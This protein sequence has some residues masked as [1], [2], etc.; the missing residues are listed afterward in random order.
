MSQQMMDACL[1]KTFRETVLFILKLKE[2]YFF[3]Y[4]RLACLVNLICDEMRAFCRFQWSSGLKNFS[5]GAAATTCSAPRPV[6]RPG[7]CWNG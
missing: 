6:K 5:C 1:H 3:S 4:I 7:R 2:C